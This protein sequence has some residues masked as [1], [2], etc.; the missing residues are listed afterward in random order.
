MDLEEAY[1]GGGRLEAAAETAPSWRGSHGR[2]AYHVA[3][4]HV[5]A[6]VMGV[7]RDRGLPA[8]LT[9]EYGNT[10]LHV[11]AAAPVRDPAA[12]AECTRILLDMRCPAGRRDDRGRT[13]YHVAADMLNAP[14]VSVFAERGVRCDS[15]RED[16]GMNALHI[17]CA[18]G[19]RFDYLRKTKPDEFRAGDVMIRGMCGDLLRCG[20]DPEDRTLIGRRAVDFAVE[21]RL[22]VTGAFLA[23]GPE[24]AGGMDLF[25]AA[26][27]NDADAVRALASDGA[28]PDALCDEGEYRG[29]TPLMIAC[30]RLASDAAAAL[31]DAGADPAYSSDGRTA[32]Y[33]LLRSLGS[34]VGTGGN[35]RSSASFTGL[36]STLV[37]R[38][39][40]PDVT[41]ENGAT[42]LCF[43]CG[44]DR[45]GWTSDGASARRLAFDGL[46][47]RG[48]NPGRADERGRTPLMAACSVGDG[49]SQ[50]MVYDL[51]AYGADPDARDADGMTA[52]MIAA[53]L[54]D[55]RGADCI[56]AVLEC[57]SPDLSARDSRG[58]DVLEIAAERGNDGA[59]RILMG[60]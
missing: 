10:A 26:V 43:A 16:D 58:R 51:L 45:M 24:E 14:M 39:G 32:V 1:F 30:R 49:E 20:I 38:A 11:L 13:A 28:D 4:E 41:A 53:D 27:M 29:M 44:Y 17:V 56:R 7:L 48:A 3:A 50:G 34:T 37:D 36:L 18:A 52:V 23:G 21:N 47:G 57:C 35:D 33:H 31:L 25:Q 55:G 6:E 9:D 12:M 5:D 2:T 8:G 59:L 22:K 54:P 40:T 42:A 15:V 19:H 46:L 60:R